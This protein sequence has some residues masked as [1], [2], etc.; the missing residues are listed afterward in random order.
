MTWFPL[1]YFPLKLFWSSYL[2]LNKKRNKEFTPKSQEAWS[3]FFR[4]EIEAQ[5]PAGI[6]SFAFCLLKN[7][8]PD[9]P[10]SSIFG[11]EDFFSSYPGGFLAE[12]I[13]YLLTPDDTEN[14]KKFSLAAAERI[15][16]LLFLEAPMTSVKKYWNITDIHFAC[17]LALHEHYAEHIGVETRKAIKF[18]LLNNFIDPQVAIGLTLARSLLE[19]ARYPSPWNRAK[20]FIIKAFTVKEKPTPPP[21]LNILKWRAERAL[22]QEKPKTNIE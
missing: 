15:A 9:F 3:K 4:E 8:F 19:Q 22:T 2:K 20:N 21:N 7:G 5:E 1:Q 6:Y 12:H 16:L 10:N 14:H 18:A 13:E 11:S 17:A